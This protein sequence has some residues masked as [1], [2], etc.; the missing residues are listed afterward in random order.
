MRTLKDAKEIKRRGCEYCG[1]FHKSNN[2][3]YCKKGACPYEKDLKDIK[4][5]FA[6]EYDPKS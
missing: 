4:E 1:E 2:V 6:K 3:K 5:D